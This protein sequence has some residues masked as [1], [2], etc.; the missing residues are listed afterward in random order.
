MKVVA[1]SS[2]KLTALVPTKLLPV[3]V[4]GVPPASG[5]A[6]GLTALTDGAA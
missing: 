3:T 5:P 4:T 1:A 2:P 6:T